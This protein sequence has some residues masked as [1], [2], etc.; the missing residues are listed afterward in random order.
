MLFFDRAR[1]RK[2][3]ASDRVAILVLARLL[4]ML[5]VLGIC[6]GRFAACLGPP[7]AQRHWLAASLPELPLTTARSPRTRRRPQ[8]QGELTRVAASYA[9]FSSD[10]QDAS[11]IAQQRR[12][13]RDKAAEHGHAI[14][15]A[16]EF[17]DEAVSG[18][19]RDRDGLNA[20]LAAAH[21]GQ[22]GTLYFES[23]S[24][25]AREF[26]ITMP[27]LKE[28]VY[29][30]HVRVISVTEGIDSASGN[31]ELLAIFRSWMHQEFLKALRSAVL[32]GQE[33]AVLHDHSVGDWCLGYG[34]EPIPGSEAARRGRHPRP[35]MRYVINEGH[36]AWVRRIFHWFVQERRPLGWIARELTRQGAPKDHR[37]TTPGWHHAYVKKVLRNHKYNG[38]WPWGKKTNVR[39][40]LTGQ[41]WQ[42]DRPVAETVPWERERPHLRIIDDATFFRAQALLDEYE[43]KWNAARKERGR[44]AGSAP[45]SG[46]PRHLLQGLVKCAAC[47]STFQVSGANGRYLG[48]AGFLRGLCPCKTRLPRALAERV[49]LGAISERILTNPGWRE[50]VWEEAQASW[51]QQQQGGP[52]ERQEAEQALASVNQKIQ[53]LLDV[54]E[55][56]T[57]DP[58]VQDRLAQRRQERLELE[59]R[60][61]GLRQ[62]GEAPP[63]PPNWEWVEA[64]LRELHEVLIGGGPAAALGLRGLIGAV[65]VTE[66]PRPGRKRKALR[67]RFTLTR[68]ALARSMSLPEKPLPADQ[69]RTE[70]VTVDFAELPPWAEVANRVKE[71][72]DAGVSQKEIAA[73]IPCRSSWVAKALAWRYR[74]RGLPVPD[75]RGLRKR[76]HKA[77]KAEGWRTGPRPCGTRGC[78]CRRSPSGWAAARTRSPARWRTGSAPV[79]WTCLMA[80]PEGRTSFTSAL[81]RTDHPGR[82]L[83]PPTRAGSSVGTVRSTMP[84]LY[85][86]M[87]DF[88]YLW[89]GPVRNFRSKS[90]WRVFL[91]TDPV[92]QM[93]MVAVR[94]GREG[95]I[96]DSSLSQALAHWALQRQPSPSS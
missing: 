79:V 10:L 13:C 25:L 62:A 29:V 27:M 82:T 7:L 16:L 47:G 94:N 91:P 89:A 93:L 64:R 84:V 5:A 69:E 37:A 76:L 48:C 71:L 4:P 81:A 51:R 90:F 15:P 58:E 12:K 49:L 31:W 65:V 40:P 38:L 73:R 18:T 24:R 55:N 43:A 52:R 96:Q 34:S 23:L 74:E 95:G 22:F 60:L 6:L 54:I 9:R 61:Q 17:A 75:G 33:E 50:A 78:S 66:I 63:R 26:V 21:D 68:T 46:H 83:R 92:T 20:M 30:H 32:R 1:N 77:T 85:P 19:R 45:D 2:R 41:L 39:N 70:E 88:F 67:G 86:G 80:G 11:S 44:L 57:A 59:R 36:A 42:E 35:R 56:G 8:G 87:V 14:P 72:F 53:R 28:L 3:S